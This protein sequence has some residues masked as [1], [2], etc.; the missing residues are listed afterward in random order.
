MHTAATHAFRSDTSGSLIQ[1]L[2]PF[3]LA[4]CRICAQ[5]CREWARAGQA[6][7]ANV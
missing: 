5:A 4:P 7:V 2:P 3:P 1:A 6:A